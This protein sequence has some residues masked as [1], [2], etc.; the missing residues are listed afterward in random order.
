[1]YGYIRPD[2]SELR[3]R[4]YELFRAAYC[5]LCETLRERCGLASRLLVN[6]D[7]TF[8]AMVLF[9][10]RGESLPRRCPVHPLRKRLCVCANDALSAAA[11]YSVILSWWKLRD[12]AK[13]ETGAASLASVS[14][15]L[16]LKKAYEKAAAARPGRLF[17]Y[18]V[19]P[20]SRHQRKNRAAAHS[21]KTVIRPSP[22]RSAC[23][24][25]TPVS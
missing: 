2:K 17:L 15:S 9:D 25:Q 4:E 5:G 24:S 14:A 8:M 22:R 20:F 16:A 12:N 11:D 21:E 6:Y 10:G 7:M 3:V 19:S 23:S 1:M 18:S 13:D